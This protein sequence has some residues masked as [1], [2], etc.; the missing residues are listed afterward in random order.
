MI[1]NAT[2][3]EQFEKEFAL[4]NSL[5]IEQKFAIVDGLW[6]EGMLLGVLPPENL[7]EGIEIDIRI[8]RILNCLK[9][10]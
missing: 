5:S 8:S 1:K 6:C 2:I 7:L 3:L 9:S 10:Y 4:N